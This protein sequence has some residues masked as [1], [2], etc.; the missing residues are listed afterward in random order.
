[1]WCKKFALKL[2]RDP[3]SGVEARAETM[4][5]MLA[6]ITSALSSKNRETAPKGLFAGRRPP[7]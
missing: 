2:P 7:E 5:P 1:M 4:F 3:V 6:G